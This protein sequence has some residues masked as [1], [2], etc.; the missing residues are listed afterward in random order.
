M[1]EPEELAGQLGDQEWV[2]KL[3]NFDDCAAIIFIIIIYLKMM[4]LFLFQIH[5]LKNDERGIASSQINSIFKINFKMRM[6]FISKY[7]L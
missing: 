6:I 2:T 3:I 4:M 1:V 7:L 5:I